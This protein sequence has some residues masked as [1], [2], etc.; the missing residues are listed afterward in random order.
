MKK[1]FL[2]SASTAALLALAACGGGGGDSSTPQV[3][4]SDAKVNASPAT[5]AAMANQTFTF[6]GGIPALGTSG[7]ATDLTFTTGS[8]FSASAGGKTA[9]GTTGYGSCIFTVTTTSFD[10][11]HPLGVLNTPSRIDPCQIE[12]ESGGVAATGVPASVN[13]RLVLAELASRDITTA[14]RILTDGQLMVGEALF[15]TVPTAPPT[16]ATGGSGL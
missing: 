9:S 13:A 5:T 6:A 8:S 12:V 16:G 7:T 3:A 1:V 4:A 14:I 11:S 2:L 10:P 15:G